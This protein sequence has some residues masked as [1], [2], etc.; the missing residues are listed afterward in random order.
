ML[1]SEIMFLT[2]T[3]I[4][5]LSHCFSSRH[6]PNQTPD[7]FCHCPR[8]LSGVRLQTFRRRIRG[9]NNYRFRRRSLC[10]YNEA[11]SNGLWRGG[12]CV[13]FSFPSKLPSL[14]PSIRSV[15][16]IRADVND[17]LL[18]SGHDS[19]ERWMIIAAVS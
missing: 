5:T 15:F 3:A 2:V 7:I 4:I 14:Y 8:L 6:R 11:M 16:P 10:T 18:I 12:K 19:Y 17:N 13:S 1:H 9:K